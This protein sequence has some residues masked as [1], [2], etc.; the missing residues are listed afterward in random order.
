MPNRLRRTVRFAANAAPGAAA[1]RNG[2]A[3]V[4][5]IRGMGRLLEL[6]V[7]VEGEAEPRS[8]YLLD[9]KTVDDA[10][11]RHAAPTLAAECDRP[12]GG[13][14]RSALAA[15]VTA[16]A[17]ALPV[18]LRW[19]RLRLSPY[20]ALAMDATNTGTAILAVRFD[21]S[22]SHRLNVPEWSEEENRRR[23]GKCNNP[24]GHGHNYQLEPRVEVPVAG[25]PL[26]IEALEAVVQELVIDR[27]DH[28]H[29]NVDTREFSDDGGLNPSVENIARVCFETLRD[30]VS[31]LGPGVRLRSVRVWET[32]RTSSEYPA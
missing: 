11:R 24:S 23:F 25:P 9:I 18:P 10:V 28:K 12:G 14:P 22:A 4:P 16:L 27:F 26:S 15:A 29:L 3:G 20:H 8:G 30:P 32:D 7:E 31:S 2:F 21:F 19:V 17:N 13:E 1:G 6:D 5:P